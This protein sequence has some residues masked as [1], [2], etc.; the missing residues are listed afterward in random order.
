[1]NWFMWLV[2]LKL[3]LV[4]QIDKK[5]LGRIFTKD[6]LFNEREVL[7]S[8]ILANGLYLQLVTGVKFKQ[9]ASTQLAEYICIAFLILND[10]N[11]VLIVQPTL[12][13]LRKLAEFCLHFTLI[14][15]APVK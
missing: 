4:I 5:K 11:L 12:K 8:N 3:H 14:I 6:N 9:F 15:L 2:Y 7:V 10:L 1:M 13:N